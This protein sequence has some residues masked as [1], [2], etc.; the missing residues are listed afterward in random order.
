MSTEEFVFLESL[1]VVIALAIFWFTWIR[2]R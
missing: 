1:L 2:G